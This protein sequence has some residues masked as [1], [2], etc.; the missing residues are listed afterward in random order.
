MA[1][2]HIQE[3]EQLVRLFESCQLPRTQW[4]HQTHL[5]VAFWFLVHY[6]QAEAI[7]RIRVGVQRYNQAIGIENSAT[8]GYHEKIT[9]FWIRRIQA[10]LE[11]QVQAQF[12]L[13]QW[14]E[15]IQQCNNPKLPLQYYSPQ[16]L[17]SWQARSAWVE[18]DLQPLF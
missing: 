3:L 4:T 16:Y 13:E 8:S 10:V 11:Q 1:H 14:D 17:M 15:L 2:H 6:P 9:L 12:T 5:I 18:P 7:A